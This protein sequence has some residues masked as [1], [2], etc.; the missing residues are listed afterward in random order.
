V[1]VLEAGSK[2]WMGCGME[3]LRE[4]VAKCR[5][6]RHRRRGAGRRFN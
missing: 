1:Y 6:P 3:A 2:S 4:R 5:R